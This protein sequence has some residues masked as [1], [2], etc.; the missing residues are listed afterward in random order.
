M[1]ECK[2]ELKNNLLIAQRFFDPANRFEELED[3]PGV[4]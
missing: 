1:K 3:E 4:K 2:A